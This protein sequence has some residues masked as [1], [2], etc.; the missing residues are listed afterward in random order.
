MSDAGPRGKREC[1][2]PE[3][4]GVSLSFL[5]WGTASQQQSPVTG[6]RSPSVLA[7]PH[8]PVAGVPKGEADLLSPVSTGLE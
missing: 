1:P 7:C 6:T 8:L 5:P 3:G 2:N 4:F